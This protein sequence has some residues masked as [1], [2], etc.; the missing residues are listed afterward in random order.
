MIRYRRATVYEVRTLVEG[1]DPDFAEMIEKMKQ[2]LEP[3][4]E[5]ASLAA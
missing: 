4:T 1:G 3:P 2:A 5:D